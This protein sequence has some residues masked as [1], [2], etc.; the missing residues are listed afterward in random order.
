MCNKQSY[1]SFPR[2][3][4]FIC[5]CIF[6]VMYN[7]FIYNFVHVPP[8]TKYTSITTE[9][10][11][12]FF[13]AILTFISSLLNPNSCLSLSQFLFS[14]LFYQCILLTSLHSAVSTFI[15]SPQSQLDHKFLL[16]CCTYR[17]DHA[18]RAKVDDQEI[19]VD[20]LMEFNEKT[21]QMKPN[22]ESY[23]HPGETRNFMETWILGLDLRC[24][25]YLMDNE[26]NKYLK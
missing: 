16:D 11:I 23:P 12:C 1:S 9:A 25:T 2:F 6:W 3:S 4:V 15:Y 26:L 10:L 5:L 24:N 7:I 22:G 17:L 20:W 18:T 13:I 21:K 8:Q 14:I 19:F